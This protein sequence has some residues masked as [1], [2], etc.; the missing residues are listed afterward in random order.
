[1]NACAVLESVVEHSLTIPLSIVYLVVMVF[2]AIGSA[3]LIMALQR[4][5]TVPV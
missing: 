1:M 4:T 5:S 3:D 2:G